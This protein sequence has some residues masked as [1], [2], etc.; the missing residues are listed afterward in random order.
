[1]RDDETEDQERLNEDYS[2]A[3]A[4]YDAASAVIVKRMENANNELDAKPTAAE[5]RAEEETRHR[6]VAARRRICQSGAH[7]LEWLPIG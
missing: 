5:I 4:A 6:L 7:S 3:C 1:M 2:D